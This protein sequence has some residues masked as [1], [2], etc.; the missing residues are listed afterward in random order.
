MVARAGGYYMAAFKGAQGVTQ[1]DLL[2]PTI[3]NVVVDAVVHH[4]VSVMVE[5]AEE[6][7]ERGQEDRHQNYLFYADDGM[8]ASSEPR[9]LQGRI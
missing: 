3:F 7:G 1:G 6:R 4:W 2:P 9:W 8:V 5:G